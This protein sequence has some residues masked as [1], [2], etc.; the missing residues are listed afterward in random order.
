MKIDRNRRS[1][2]TRSLINPAE[3]YELNYWTRQLG[4][5]EQ[6]LLGAISA[7]GPQVDS[8]RSYLSRQPGSNR[9]SLRAA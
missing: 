5:T 8:V 1:G 4:C 9:P 2:Q 3:G 6:Q 7:V